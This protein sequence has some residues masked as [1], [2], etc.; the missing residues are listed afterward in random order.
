ML[1]VRFLLYVPSNGTRPV[2][3]PMAAFRNPH[4]VTS[5]RS[6]PRRFA[7]YNRV[8]IYI[9]YVMKPVI[10][11]AAEGPVSRASCFDEARVYRMGP[12]LVWV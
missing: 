4:Q 10:H 7:F 9:L 3:G 5:N 6:G 1:T 8:D 12:P 11:Q 2:L